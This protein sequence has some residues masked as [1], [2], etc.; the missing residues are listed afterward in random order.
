L[1]KDRLVAKPDRAERKEADRQF[2]ASAWPELKPVLVAVG[3]VV[4]GVVVIVTIAVRWSPAIFAVYPLG[5]GWFVYVTRRMTAE[6]RRRNR[7][8]WLRVTFVI[9]TVLLPWASGVLWV[10]DM[11][12]HPAVEP[13]VPDR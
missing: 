6:M 3:I 12:R 11:R 4:V 8:R 2:R 9:V 5:V 1:S 10:T 13:K 7:P